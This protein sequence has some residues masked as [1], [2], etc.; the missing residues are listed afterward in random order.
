MK[1]VIVFFAS[2]LLFL[3]YGQSQ[4]TMMT[5]NFDGQSV[6]LT[7]NPTTAWQQTS[8]YFV[9]A[10]YAYRGRVPHAMGSVTYLETPTYN[11]STYYEVYLRFNHICKVSPSDI[12]RIEY[13]IGGTVWQ[14]IPTE[15]YLGKGT[16]TL[17]GFNA[18][19]YAA[20]Q[21]NDSVAQ[22]LLSWWR[23]EV[24]NLSNDV[25]YEAQVQFRFVIQ[26]GNVSGSQISYGW[27]I[28]NLEVI[29]SPTGANIPIVEFVGTYPLD[30]IQTTGGDAIT[31]K[32]TTPSGSFVQQPYLKW[33]SIFNNVF[34][35]DS[36]AMTV[37]TDSTFRANL[38][39]FGIG[40]KVVYSVTGRE[41]YG[42]HTTLTA[43]YY[44]AP[45]DN[46]TSLPNDSAKAVEIVSP[47]S[48]TLDVGILNTIEVRIQNLGIADLDSAII[49]YQ[50]NNDPVQSYAWYGNLSWQF[51]S[52]AIP[53]GTFTPQKGQNDTVR[54]WVEQPNGT[55]I[56]VTDTLTVGFFGCGGPVSEVTLVSGTNIADQIRNDVFALLAKCGVNSDVRVL[57]PGGSY[58]TWAFSN[59]DVANQPWNTTK[60]YRLVIT[61]ISGQ[62]VTIQCTSTSSVN[63]IEINSGV[64]NLT[65]DGLTLDVSSLGGS[66]PAGVRFLAN[67]N[68]I[69]INNCTILA[70]IT[71]G[72][73]VTVGFGIYRTG[74]STTMILKNV[75]ITNNTIN[76]GWA[77]I[78]IEGATGN[79]RNDNIV[80]EGNILDNGY[81]S[82]AYIT[83]SINVRIANNLIRGRTTGTIYSGWGGVYTGA[84][85]VGAIVGNRIQAR[86]ATASTAAKGIIIYGLLG[87]TANRGLIAN[88][89]I[90]INNTT[91]T[92]SVGIS[93]ESG[94]S[95]VDIINNSIVFGNGTNTVGKG[96]DF[97]ANLASCNVLNNV[98][99]TGAST[100]STS[101]CAIYFSAMTPV[102]SNH[103]L[104]YN[105]YYPARLN[106]GGIKT[107][108]AAWQGVVGSGKDQNSTF[109]QPTFANFQND[110]KM[111]NWSS[112][113]CPMSL[114]V[115][116]DID[117]SLRGST[118]I[119]GCYEMA[120]VASANAALVEI[121]GIPAS[122]LAG[123]SVNI[124]AVVANLGLTTIN[125]VE[126]G[127]SIENTFFPNV[128][129]SVTLA[130]GEKDTIFLGRIAIPLGNFT[131]TAWIENIGSLTDSDPTDDTCRVVAYGCGSAFMGPYTVGG[132]NGDF[133]TL[134]EAR[135][136]LTHCTIIGEVTLEL[137]SG[138]YATN[139]EWEFSNFSLPGAHRLVITAKAGDSAIITSTVRIAEST[140][141]L[142]FRDLTFDVSSGNRNAFDFSGDV[143]N[144]HIDSCYFYGNPS[145]SGSDEALILKNPGTGSNGFGSGY[146]TG[147]RITNCYFEGGRAAIEM[148]VGN[149]NIASGT[150]TFNHNTCINNR[151][152][153]VRLHS[154]EGDSVCYNVIQSRT[155][156]SA[157]DWKGI[158]IGNTNTTY[159][160]RLGNISNNRILQRSS[161]IT[162][163]CGIELTHT[164]S[165]TSGTTML[166]NNEIILEAS[167]A[168]AA[169]I[170]LNHSRALIQYNSIYVGGNAAAKG[171][172]IN[173]NNPDNWNS[174]ASPAPEVF[175][176]GNNIRVDGTSG[177][178]VY[179]DQTTNI[180]T[181]WTM[182]Y[183][184]YSAPTYLGSFAGTNVATWNDWW[185]N[186]PADVNSVNVQPVYDNVSTS[187]R[188]SD[189]TPFEM[190]PFAAGQYDIEDLPRNNIT[191]MGAYTVDIS[192][193]N[194]LLEASNWN[195][196]VVLNIDQPIEVKVT[197]T[198]STPLTSL[199]LNYQV[200]GGQVQTYP[201]TTGPTLTAYAW[202]FLQID[203][204]A[205][206][207]NNNEVK[208]WASSING[209]PYTSND[210]LTMTCNVVPLGNW[211]MPLVSDTISE[212]SFD[213]YAEVFERSGA[214]VRTPE[215]HVVCDVYNDTIPMY[216][217]AAGLWTATIP[218]SPQ[219]Y[220]HWVY[221]SLTLTDTVQNTFTLLDST[222]IEYSITPGLQTELV[223]A[224]YLSDAIT[225]NEY[226]TF[227]TRQVVIENT[228]IEDHN[229][230]HNNVSVNINIGQPVFA[231][232]SMDIRYGILEAGKKDTVDISHLFPVAAWDSYDLELWLENPISSLPTNDTLSR[233]YEPELLELPV[234]IDFE[235][236]MP[237]ELLQKSNSSVDAWQIVSTGI[238]T[239]ISV[240]PVDGDSMIA[241]NGSIGTV[242]TLYTRPLAL[243][244]MFNPRLEF[245]YFHDT[246]ASDDV[247]DVYITQNAQVFYVHLA[248]ISKQNSV[249]GWQFYSFNL[250]N[251]TNGNC[252]SV[253]FEAMSESPDVTQYIDE[254]SIASEQELEV[255]EI[256]IYPELTACD[257]DNRDVYV[258]VRTTTNQRVD[259]SQ[260]QT[261]LALD[262]PGYPTFDYPLNSGLMAG[263]SL[264]TFKV[265]TGVDFTTGSHLLT[266]YLTVAIDNNPSNDSKT[267]TLDIRPDIELEVIHTTGGTTDCIAMGGEIFQTIAITNIGNLDAFDIPLRL[268]VHSSYLQPMSDTLESVL[269]GETIFFQFKEAY[270]IPNELYYNVVAFADL[271]CDINKSNNSN[272]GIMECVD[273]DD[274]ALEEFVHPVEGTVDEVGKEVYLEVKISN[275]SPDMSY[276]AVRIHA[277]IYDE[278]TLYDALS[279]TIAYLSE[280]AT[281]FY[282]FTSA[283]TVPPTLNYTV[284]VFIDQVDNYSH[285]DTISIDRKTNI[286]EDI[287]VVAIVSPTEGGM[288]HIGDEIYITAT[289]ANLS[290]ER[291]FEVVEINA[292]I[293]AVGT[294]DILLTET[295]ADLEA[296]ESRNYTF[297]AP[298]AAP[299][300]KN[301][302]VTVFVNS[303][304]IYP[305]NDTA[306]ISRTTDVGIRGYSSN[307]FDLGQNV[308]NPAKNNTRIK[309]N[310]PNDGQV[311]FTVYSITGQTLHVET[312]NAHSG[313][314]N[315]VFNTTDL[316]NGIYYYSMEYNGERLVKKMTIKR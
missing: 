156:G 230:F 225:N 60:D 6:S 316:A 102:Y 158:M 246:V 195:D 314:N 303:M 268:E 116:E 290:P 275:Y 175:I 34:T 220:N 149:S 306:T 57:V 94:A 131:A 7:A 182:A 13:R 235:T 199:T 187:L 272:I 247:M 101:N 140:V 24:F 103:F 286:E 240:L 167:N 93:F 176:R 168:N 181:R 300:A 58:N 63:A 292:L 86:N 98:I 193:P 258:V 55:T 164:S 147:F 141:N 190:P 312:Q 226:C 32:I 174:T 177:H 283:Y 110:L 279:E 219:Y 201:W 71:T 244:G 16:Y 265:A 150:I 229:F 138:T 154:V 237:V 83:N 135:H 73:A 8:D 163:P 56:Q 121:L 257:F 128:N 289:V 90:I 104:D 239:D 273:V 113:S 49:Y 251:Y 269:A 291:T 28:D 313:Q 213:V 278:N 170:Q 91:S 22:P 2:I 5:E 80:I 29:A 66:T 194:V 18:A 21:A 266:A 211:A 192:E 280:D 186:L 39:Q 31:A 145:S 100:S 14:P 114:L 72:T 315:I 65:F 44:I 223:L 99:R 276:N 162:T 293:Q 61:P 78:R 105:V 234:K 202:Y 263:N 245:W 119:R 136:A 123:D 115:Q 33:V 231:S 188:L 160:D 109:T 95:I 262:V 106:A 287:E 242:G 76:G 127:W 236:G 310:L 255:T 285:N 23:E 253:L 260:T 210:T 173:F 81:N 130:R 82:N 298:Y 48:A 212:V 301:Y 97:Y 222:F 38:P 117:G 108:I 277:E 148:H 143:R 282:Q 88:N 118:T 243:Q 151:L 284:K 52:P 144:I 295:L 37:L 46:M 288:D 261:S 259:F 184:N 302:T 308:P 129:Q 274:I 227:V 47:T 215:I 281:H 221:Y 305:N 139:S 53:I 238:G 68:N 17:Q 297:I 185:Q 267:Q 12:A 153:G 111:T 42:S 216:K 166:W 204:F 62:T 112:F 51:L 19:S 248:T 36:V 296:G 133:A 50:V 161:A 249:Y 70:P 309:Y 35:T 264:D 69:T 196:E 122:P 124:R 189:Y 304:D 64:N 9:S 41:N 311:I 155:T 30:T 137:T 172:R 271:W 207:Q 75:A 232:A 178:P 157:A 217:N 10:P 85:V 77:N 183:N 206:P 250:S 171:I 165:N 214:V 134:T 208:V 67:T 25:A 241:F 40:T 59:L 20:W 3:Q 146:A 252:M 79:N 198:S 89:E 299:A 307:G 142:T 233:I 4:T 43:G 74:T 224:E 270:T 87:E 152:Y 228:G 256:Y 180:S 197:N 120:P 54:V 92:S 200:N 107:T 294:Q 203:E 11:L 1:R 15:T 169:G 179:F 27:L 254:I 191:A 26:H 205:V 209:T 125:Q 132:I 126:L 96:I 218:V 45:P 159:M 84:N